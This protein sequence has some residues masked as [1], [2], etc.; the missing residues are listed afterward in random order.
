MPALCM[1]VAPDEFE[2]IDRRVR[3]IGKRL[4]VLRDAEHRTPTIQR[5]PR[6]SQDGSMRCDRRWYSLGA[7]T[8][9]IES[10]PICS[11]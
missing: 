3:L 5:F 9:L 2:A 10:Q 7:A 1:E 11:L 6:P 8:E 4:S